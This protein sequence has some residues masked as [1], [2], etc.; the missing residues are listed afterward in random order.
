MA[1]ART[2]LRPY[3]SNAA[4]QVENERQR[5]GHGEAERQGVANH[6]R[7]VPAV[8]CQF[9][10][11]DDI[12]AEIGS[13]R[14]E[15]RERHGYAVLAE[16]RGPERAGEHRDQ[17]DADERAAELAQNGDH[18]ARAEGA[19]PQP[20]GERTPVLTGSGKRRQAEGR[21]LAQA[22]GG[23]AGRQCSS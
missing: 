14:A 9:A 4:T 13:D 3:G 2:T 10:R 11:N 15:G 7:S 21:A 6:A 23:R 1:M 20:H 22:P 19:G 17:G 8:P 16:R 5:S 12:E 18:H